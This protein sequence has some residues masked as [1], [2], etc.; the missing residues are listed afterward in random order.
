[1][2]NLLTGFHSSARIC[3]RT[4]DRRWDK[5][6]E[7]LCH[8]DT[9]PSFILPEKFLA[10]EVR[11]ISLVT[12]CVRRTQRRP[13]CRWSCAA[14]LLN[15]TA[16]QPPWTPLLLI[17]GLTTWPEPRLRHSLVLIIVIILVPGRTMIWLHPDLGQSASL[18]LL[19]IGVRMLLCHRLLHVGVVVLLEI[20][21]IPDYSWSHFSDNLFSSHLQTD[22]SHVWSEIIHHNCYQGR[23][24][25]YGDIFVIHIHKIIRICFS[26]EIVTHPAEVS[27]NTE[28]PDQTC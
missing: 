3:R 14:P 19:S 2:E 12:G 23:P 16:P 7:C 22:T 28:L 20:V 27:I 17:M 15:W 21:F 6:T 25:I 9:L 18:D 4:C 8:W 24:G 13:L 5:S 11:L 26:T 1:M 10:E